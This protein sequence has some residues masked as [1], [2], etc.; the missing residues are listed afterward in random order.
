MTDGDTP[1][2]LNDVKRTYLDNQTDSRPCPNDCHGSLEPVEE[3]DEWVCPSCRVTE[4]GDFDPPEPSAVTS[5]RQYSRD[6]YANSGHARLFGGYTRAY[7]A[8]QTGEREYAI[9]M[10]DA[11]TEGLW[12]PHARPNAD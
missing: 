8:A 6:E 4:T 3:G 11:V 1:P 12:T 9:D 10:Y 2:S 5:G 7:R